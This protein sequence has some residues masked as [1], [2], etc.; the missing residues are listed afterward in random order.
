MTGK[1][2]VSGDLAK[3]LKWLRGE[4]YRNFLGFDC[5]DLSGLAVP[6]AQEGLDNLLAIVA[7][8]DRYPIEATFQALKG[9][10]ASKKFGAWKWAPNLDQAIDHN[11]RSPLRKGPYLLRSSGRE[12]ADEELKNLSANALAEQSIQTEG[13][14]E[15]LIEFGVYYCRTGRFLDEKTT[16]LCAGSRSVGGRVPYGGWL[17][18]FRE[19]CLSD[20]YS[21]DG[22][23]GDLRARRVVSVR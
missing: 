2:Q 21:P 8:D 23:V 22:A 4:Y 1:P 7:I 11:D 5:P 16:T 3:E 19:F 6:T 17:P 18:D 10:L 20:W 12:A 15:Y 13:V 9:Q 14:L